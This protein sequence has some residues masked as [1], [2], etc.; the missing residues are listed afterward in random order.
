M[1]CAM[2][3][4]FSATDIAALLGLG[5]VLVPALLYVGFELAI[6]APMAPANNKAK[7][8]SA[9]TAPVHKLSAP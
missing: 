3:R 4:S 2:A 6:G 7:E 9:V 8:R 1:K 5:V